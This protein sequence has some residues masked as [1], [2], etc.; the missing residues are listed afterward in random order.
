MPAIEPRIKAAIL[1]V[2]GLEKERGKPEVEPI[3]F[4]PRI[5]IPVLMLNGK[6]DHFF[7]IESSQKPFYQLLGTPAEHK[8][9]VVYEGGH[10]VPRE[11]LIAESLDWLDKYLGRGK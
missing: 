2:A 4:L 10:N 3:N 7:P 8:R 11:R 1:Y 5:K 6:Y 9:Y